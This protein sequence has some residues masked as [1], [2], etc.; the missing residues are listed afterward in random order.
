MEVSYEELVLATSE[1]L[2][3]ICTFL[4]IEYDKRML[5][6]Y[7]RTPHRLQE[8]GGRFRVDGS[9]IVTRE[10]RLGQQFQT[11]CPPDPSRVCAW[12]EA[13]SDE[14][15]RRFEAVAGSMLKNFGFELRT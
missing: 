1:V 10:Q 2:E 12:K 3:R 9:P 7:E 13:M 14:E 6:Y 15:R 8:H 11:T 5:R 4:D